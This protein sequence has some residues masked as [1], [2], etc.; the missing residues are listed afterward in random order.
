MIL[1]LTRDRA[2]VSPSG[3]QGTG[4]VVLWP[5]DAVLKVDTK[6]EWFDETCRHRGE[7]IGYL[8]AL[9]LFPEGRDVI[10]T[11]RIYRLNVEVVGVV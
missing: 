7:P 8:A 3:W 6:G 9:A 5:E 2:P 10:E 1:Q 11:D 4:D